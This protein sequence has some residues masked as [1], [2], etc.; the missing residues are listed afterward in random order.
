MKTYSGQLRFGKREEEAMRCVLQ[1]C[2]LDIS[3]GGGGSFN[4]GDNDN[5]EDI[6][7]IVKAKKGI[8]LFEW[9]LETYK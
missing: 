1:H 9:I 6:K 4:L 7:E 8:E 2:K 5:T 3:F